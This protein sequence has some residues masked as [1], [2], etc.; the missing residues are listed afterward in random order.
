MQHIA[1]VVLNVERESTEKPIL[2][3]TPRVE[4]SKN[5]V[6]CGANNHFGKELD[7]MQQK[8]YI[9]RS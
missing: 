2:I 6:D 5:T 3:R 4:L 1:A 8:E 7:A 9:I